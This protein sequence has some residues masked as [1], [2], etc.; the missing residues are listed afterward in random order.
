VPT[1]L[2]SVATLGVIAN[3]PAIDA[4]QN[5]AAAAGYWLRRDIVRG[6]FEPGE[7]LKVEFL[8]RFYGIGHSPIREAFLLLSGSDLVVH[9]H[10]RGYSVADV[11]LEEYDDIARMYRRLYKLAID[12]AISA[13]DEAWEER[14]ILALHR[15]AKVRKVMPEGDPRARE[16]WQIAYKSFHAELLAGCGSRTLRNFLRN[17][18]DRLE[19]YANLF[20]DFTTD[21]E[22]DQH[23][24]H[25]AIIDALVARDGKALLDLVDQYLSGGTALG[26]TIRRGLAAFLDERDGASARGRI[27]PSRSRAP[28]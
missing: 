8:T 13:G 28:A 23:A 17:V 11:S 6:V 7:R 12:M 3:A 21:L 10:Q 16:S 14:V 4:G 19:R 5:P 18:G 25:R 2:P 15:S 20:G 22:R 27:R 1:A 26:K 24:E 9:E